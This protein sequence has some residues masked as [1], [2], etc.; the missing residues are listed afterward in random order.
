[1]STEEL[2]EATCRP[3]KIGACRGQVRS[4]TLAVNGIPEIIEQKASRPVAKIPALW[5]HR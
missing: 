3:W 1:M 2:F 4:R 5:F